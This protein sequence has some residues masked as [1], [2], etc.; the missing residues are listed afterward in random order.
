MNVPDWLRGPL[1]D[2]AERNAAREITRQA[3]VN[4]VRDAILDKADPAFLR[5]VVAAF[6]A[7]ALAAQQ[8]EI[9]RAAAAGEAAAG[10]SD[11]FPDLPSRLYI[12][13]GQAKAVILFTAHDWDT[14]KAV[15]ENRTSG[16]IEAA[17]ADWA[18]FEAAYNRVRPL[19]AGDLVTADVAAEL[20]GE[21][22]AAHARPA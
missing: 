9:S 5:G 3:A 2:A 17:Q 1:A 13:P 14:A 21:F 18:A 12:R 19:L 8:R 16:A 11:L 10:Q 15:L 4:T 22:S 6:A 7:K 20:A